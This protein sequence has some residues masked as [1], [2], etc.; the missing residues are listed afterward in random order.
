MLLLAEEVVRGDCRDES[1]PY[2][3]VVVWLNMPGATGYNPGLPRA[4][5]VRR[6]G[7][8]AIDIHSYVR[9]VQPTG[10]TKEMCEQATQ[11]A[12]SLVTYLGIQDAG[13]K[14]SEPSQ[15]AG[16]WARHYFL[17]IK[18]ES[19]QNH[20]RKAYHIPSYDDLAQ[21]QSFRP[22]AGSIEG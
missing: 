1:K 13:C 21:R 8:N 14:R 18:S 15:E 19:S 5:R 16:G 10:C 7:G 20:S 12:G 4:S 3:W 6:D 17:L 22:C 9:D 2:S 11:K